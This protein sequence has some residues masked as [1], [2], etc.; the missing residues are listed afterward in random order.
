[1]VAAVTLLLKTKR[2]TVA[3]HRGRFQLENK[4]IK[5]P[6]STMLSQLKGVPRK[7]RTRRNLVLLK[8]WMSSERKDKE[9]AGKASLVWHRR[10][11][12]G[13]IRASFTYH[14]P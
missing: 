6:G 13:C 4:P 12:G 5:R 10:N 14:G 9:E 1:M 7:C 3:I 2:E 8:H 11:A